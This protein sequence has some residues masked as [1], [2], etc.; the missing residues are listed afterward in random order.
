MA[1]SP[2]VDRTS[3][4]GFF[5][6]KDLTMLGFD[7][8]RNRSRK[9][10]D[11]KFSTVLSLDPGETTGY[12]LFETTPTSANMVYFGQVKTWE[13]DKAIIA[14]THLLDT[15][16]P[17][18]VVFE[19]YRIYEWKT[20]QHTN[21]EVPTLQVIGCL[22]TLCIQRSIPFTDQSAQVAKQF[23]TDEKLTAWNFYHA[24]VRHARDAIR[25]GAYYLL[26][27][28]NPISK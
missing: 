10:A 20:D 6:A 26:F 18:I 16:K 9:E 24:G 25:H 2:P 13:L 15:Y 12:A 19:A 1:K 22:K 28:K 4:G 23:V 17:N 5:L 7:E 21:S 14:F 27:G 8:I 3:A 11:R